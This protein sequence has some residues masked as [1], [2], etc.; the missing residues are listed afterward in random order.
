MSDMPLKLLTLAQQQSFDHPSDL[1]MAVLPSLVATLPAVTTATVYRLTRGGVA[2]WATT[3]DD[4]DAGAFSPL[5]DD[6]AVQEA[7]DT[8]DA[9]AAD[10]RSIYPLRADQDLLG[11]LELQHTSPPD[12]TT[13]TTIGTQLALILHNQQLQRL[14]QQQVNST[15]KLNHATDLEAVM[16]IVAENIVED[17]QFITLNRIIYDA[18]GQV[19]GA[20]VLLSANRQQAFSDQDTSLGV[21][22]AYL[23]SMRQ[24]L[25]DDGEFLIADVDHDERL[26]DDDR[27]WLRSYKVASTYVLPLTVQDELYGFINLVDTQHSL[28]LNA[29]QRQIYQNIAEQAAIILEKRDL[30][31]QTESSLQETQTLY[32]IT[33]DLVKAQSLSDIMMALYRHVG[34]NTRNIT[35]SEYKYQPD[36]SLDGIYMRHAVKDGAPIDLNKSWS[37]NFSAE[38]AARALAYTQEVGDQLEVIPDFDKQVEQYPIFEALRDQGIGSSIT[39]PLYEGDKRT[40]QITLSWSRP[41]AFDDS[42]PKILES[43]RSQISLVLRNQALLSTSRSSVQQSEQQATL[44]ET[45]NDLIISTNQEQDEQTLLDRTAKV[46]LQLTNADHIGIGILQTEG[47]VTR[48]AA[49]AP[50]TGATGAFIEGQDGGIPRRLIET[51]RPVLIP[52]IA[53][54]DYIDELGREALAGVGAKSVFIVPMFDLE[55]NLLG[56]IGFDYYERVDHFDEQTVEIAQTIASQVTINVQK[57]RLLRTSQS[58]AQKMRQ[59]TEFSQSMM[60]SFQTEDILQMSLQA[61][62]TVVQADY[63]SVLM[64]D[65]TQDTLRQVAEMWEGEKHVHQ[66]GVV[67]AEDANNVAYKAWQ[68]RDLVQIETLQANWEW[69]HPRITHLQSLMAY[70]IVSV[71]VVLG[72]MEIGNKSQVQ[73]EQTDIIAFQQ[74]SNQIAVALSNAETYTQSQKLARNKVLAND[75]ISQLQRQTEIQGILSITATELGKA[76]GATRARIRLGLD[77]PANGEDS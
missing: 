46:L 77:V 47:G 32:A 63:I 11:V 41:H 5:T 10:E 65:R 76:L 75:I 35:I 13:L 54:A 17:G 6:P 14:L 56:S 16:Q 43:M 37:D 22:V 28:T 38:D 57:L 58:Q 3:R 48:I 52:D 39:V 21:H 20:Q 60:S 15:A 23:Q 68:A 62:Q 69:K 40:H 50:D 19:T 44:L 4:I 49:E 61:T 18:Q 55:G 67:V 29:T 9:V 53:A 25:L 12:V 24:H 72:V 26:T 42:L 34:Q 30:L 31:M 71:G 74:M 64:Y 33:E 2:V 36:G 1:L 8:R 51:R 66:P 70:P 7:I 59:I 73:Y 27:T 45:M